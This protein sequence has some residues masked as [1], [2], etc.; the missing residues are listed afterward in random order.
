MAT[1]KIFRHRLGL[2][3]A[4]GFI[5]VTGALFL[6]P[7]SSDLTRTYTE[8]TFVVGI[9]GIMA[10]ATLIYYKVSGGMTRFRLT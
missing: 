10:G 7:L 3:A 4:G 6:Q 8:S 2:V 9:F 5:V 1:P